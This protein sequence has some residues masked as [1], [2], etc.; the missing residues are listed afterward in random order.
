MA[1][2]DGGLITSDPGALLLGSADRTI[3]MVGRFA[4][5][6]H[7]ARNQEMTEHSGERLVLPRSPGFHDRRVEQSKACEGM[8]QSGAAPGP[9]LQV[10]PC[11]AL[12]K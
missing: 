11:A 3:G 9:V 10:R 1:A 4:T 6:F 12:R 5:C 8:I 2:F 7:D